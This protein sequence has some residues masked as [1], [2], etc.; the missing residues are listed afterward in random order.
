MHSYLPTGGNLD[1]VYGQD[2]IAIWIEN[3]ADNKEYKDE[4]RQLYDIHKSHDDT[5]ICTQNTYYPYKPMNSNSKAK[6][7]SFQLEYRRRL[8]YYAI[9][10][11]I[12]GIVYL[13]F[14]CIFSLFGLHVDLDELSTDWTIVTGGA[15]RVE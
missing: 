12:V 6:R 3:K 1:S 2:Q 8:K 11:T 13:L 5:T 10:I 14:K 4:K 15:I 9:G 7:P